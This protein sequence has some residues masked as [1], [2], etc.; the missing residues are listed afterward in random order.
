MDSRAPGPKNK[1]GQATEPPPPTPPQL[2]PRGGCLSKSFHR[3]DLVLMLA[4][5]A[6][7]RRV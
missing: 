3:C 1:D 2:P 4:A 6:L 5:R 7:P